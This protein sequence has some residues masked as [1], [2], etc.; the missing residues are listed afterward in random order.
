MIEVDMVG[1]VKAKQNL[2]S[3]SSNSLNKQKFE[4]VNYDF[5]DKETIVINYENI[6]FQYNVKNLNFK[7]KE[8]IEIDLCSE[9][10]DIGKKHGSNTSSNL[11]ERAK[12]T[13]NNDN[14]I[15]EKIIEK[16][17][18][19]NKLLLNNYINTIMEF[20]IYIKNEFNSA[21]RGLP[22]LMRF[23]QIKTKKKEENKEIFMFHITFKRDLDGGYRVK[24]QYNFE[25]VSGLKELNCYNNKTNE[26]K[27]FIN[28]DILL[29][30]LKDSTIENIA[31]DCLRKN[32]KV[33]NGY[34]K[35][36]K[37]KKEFQN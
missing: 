29:F 13:I 21:Q 32:Y 6:K 16:R 4:F 14:K 11:F 18:V 30:E 8:L 19:D 5:Y 28:N 3:E 34:I 12:N 22:N 25:Q 35:I 1:F 31:Y 26:K 15:L 7:P 23:I 27:N 37:K 9:L 17:K 2:I 36:L 20:S 33:L 24:A 10:K